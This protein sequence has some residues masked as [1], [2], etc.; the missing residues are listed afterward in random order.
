MSWL[1]SAGR[2]LKNVKTV[3]LLNRLSASLVVERIR[4]YYKTCSLENVES[5]M[6]TFWCTHCHP[7]YATFKCR[8]RL[9]KC[10]HIYFLHDVCM[11]S[12]GQ[13]VLQVQVRQVDIDAGQ[14]RVK[15]ATFVGIG[16]K[17]RSPVHKKGR[18]RG[19]ARKCIEQKVA[20][21]K[22]K[23]PPGCLSAEPVT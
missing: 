3:L 17:K 22:G 16:D 10:L 5:F 6:H 19:H 18:K 12:Y 7:S 4:I 23:V 13:Y 14:P 21:G 11:Y 20:K 1:R 15:K 2:K 8:T 9:K